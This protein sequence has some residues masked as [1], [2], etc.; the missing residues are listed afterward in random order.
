MIKEISHQKKIKIAKEHLDE[1]GHVNNVQYVHWVEE[2]AIEHWD[3]VKNKTPYSEQ[4]WV[5]VDHHIQYK[6]E[7]FEGEELT[8]KTYPQAP[9]G[10]RQPRKV[11]FYRDGKLIVDSRTLWVLVDKDTKKIT[12]ISEDWLDKLYKNL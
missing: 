9:K 4:L 8:V 3:L 6:K 1:N 7:G 10:L 12:R 5:M 2:I 11:E